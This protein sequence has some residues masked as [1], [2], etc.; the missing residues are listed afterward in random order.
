MTRE[1]IQTY[2]Q[3]GHTKTLRVDSSIV[4]AYP[5]FVRE[6]RIRK[7]YGAE[8]EFL[9]HGHDESGLLFQTN[10]QTLD[11]LVTNLESYFEK[12]ISAW[13]NFNQS[14]G[15]PERQEN[16]SGQTLSWRELQTLF[17]KLVPEEFVLRI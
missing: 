1:E 8:I 14:G 12:P 2:V 3:L 9:P 11:E 17:Q 13:I 6:V 4:Q 10:F 5:S 16:V 7:N 15:Y